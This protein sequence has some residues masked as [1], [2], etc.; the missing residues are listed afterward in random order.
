M[1]SIEE[2]LVNFS[3]ILLSII[4]ALFTSKLDL[5]LIKSPGIDP[6]VNLNSFR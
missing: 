4:M 2:I 6:T 3:Y 1:R 5:P